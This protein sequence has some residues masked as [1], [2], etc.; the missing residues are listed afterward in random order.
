VADVCILKFEGRPI[1][2][3]EIFAEADVWLGYFIGLA[4]YV[5]GML[6]TYYYSIS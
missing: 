6:V 2:A 4:G 5:L 1:H 3:A